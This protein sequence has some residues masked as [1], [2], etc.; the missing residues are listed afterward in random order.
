[1]SRAGSRGA[2]LVL[3]V[4]WLGGCTPSSSTTHAHSSPGVPV[5]SFAGACAGT[6]LTDA[7][8]PTWAQG[9][10]SQPQAPWG[11]PWALGTGGEAVAYVFAGQLVAGSSPRVDGSN[12]KVLWVAQGGPPNFVVEAHPLGLDQPIVTI[13]GG[14]S[15][16]DLPTA[17][18]W[19]FHLTWGQGGQAGS[20]TVNLEV[21]PSGSLPSPITYRTL[22][23][24]P[25]EL[26][27]VA[28]GSP[29]PVSPVTLLGGVAPR[30]GTPLRLGFGNP[31][32]PQGAYAFNKTVLDYANPPSSPEV[33]LR[34]GR[35]DGPGK[36]YFGGPGVTPNEA[37]A[38]VS[39]IDP[40]GGRAPFYGELQMSV[41]SSAVFYTYPTTAGC[42]GIQV[43][44]EGFSEV[45]V[46]TVS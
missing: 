45:V 25:L 7:L 42:Y 29:C 6:V 10:W 13:A 40:Q 19:T 32:G 18:C 27:I 24:R 35:L 4:L 20:S 36:L 8:P 39:V 17:G 33:V 43:D 41:G 3:L 38:A 11:V 30:V 1:V 44:S 34:G 14:P 26:P 37:A 22:R 5:H 28:A 31:V 12:N 23:A 21:L 46:F 16:V 15:I 2:V 9:G